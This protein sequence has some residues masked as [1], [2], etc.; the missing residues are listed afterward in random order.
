MKTRHTLFAIALHLTILSVLAYKY[1][2]H[3]TDHPIACV[4]AVFSTLVII[5]TLFR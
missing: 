1:G 2:A 4:F 5:R 3:S